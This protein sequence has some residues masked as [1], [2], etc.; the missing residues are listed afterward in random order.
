MPNCQ[1]GTTTTNNNTTTSSR[2]SRRIFRRI[3]RQIYLRN[4]HLYSPHSPSQRNQDRLL[5]I[6]SK[7]FGFVSDPTCNIRTNVRT[8]IE[9][10]S[11]HLLPQPIT[12]KTIYNLCHKST[13]LPPNLESILGLNLGFGLNLPPNKSNLPIDF[14]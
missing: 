14:T 12:N 9:H 13:K 11:Q 10:T 2:L 4:H 1:N 6:C 7:R 8:T 3:S 5:S